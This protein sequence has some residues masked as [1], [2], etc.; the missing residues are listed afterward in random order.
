MAEERKTNLWVLGRLLG[1]SSFFCWGRCESKCRGIGKNV[2]AKREDM[3][4][5][6]KDP[7]VKL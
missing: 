6:K 4:E 1:S 2:G 3:E 5:E 7:W